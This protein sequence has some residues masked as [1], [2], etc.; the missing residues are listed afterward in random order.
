MDCNKCIWADKGSG[1]KVFCPFSS[2]VVKPSFKENLLKAMEN[3][4]AALQDH[5]VQD[6]G[7]GLVGRNAEWREVKY[8]KE[9]IERGEFD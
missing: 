4:M 6:F 1:T 7:G 9:A 8:W 5:I 2:C 3:R